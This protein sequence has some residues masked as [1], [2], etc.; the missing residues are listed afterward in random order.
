MSAFP[1]TQG[2]YDAA[3]E[4][5]ACGVAFVVDVP[6]R[7]THDLVEQGLQ[8]LRNLEHRGASGAEPETGDGAGILTQVP[9]AFYRA[10]LPV[11][12]PEAGR[13]AVGTA[14][15]PTNPRAAVDAQLAIEKI[16]AEEGL[17]VLTWRD[18]PIDPKG[19][20]IGRTAAEVMPVF[21]QVFL[22]AADPALSSYA[23]ERRAFVARKR[24]ENETGTYFPSLSTR[25]VVYKGMLTTEQ[26]QPFFPDL[27]DE[28]YASA[29][30]LVHSRFSTNTFPS[31]PLAHPYRYIAH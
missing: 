23:L 5:D 16:A 30:A 14:F 22:T 12:L 7:V 6:G 28:R 11:E 24:A 29:L 27:S 21:R 4:H 26:L 3:N 13:Y 25:T 9:D 1:A 18:L 2:L 8:A 20:G 10:V 15:L 31:W 17:R 19:A